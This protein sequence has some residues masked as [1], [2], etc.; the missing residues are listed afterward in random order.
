[1]DHT[2]STLLDE[3]AWLGSAND[4]R[5]TERPRRMLNITPDTG[6]LLWI[7]IRATGASRILEVGMSNVLPYR[8][9]G[10]GAPDL[11]RE[12]G[13]GH[14]VR[15]A[16]AELRVGA[17]DA[18]GRTIAEGETNAIGQLSH[19]RERLDADLLDL[20]RGL[21]EQHDVRPAERSVQASKQRQE[22]RPQA[23]KIGPGDPCRPASR[24][25]P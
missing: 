24:R 10:C 21:P 11:G 12:G 17:H 16:N 25:Q 6:R 14:P 1:M 15:S 3:L 22:L 13:A 8:W 19:H 9:T 4:A 2:L 23:S 20:L 18:A 7:M 5:E